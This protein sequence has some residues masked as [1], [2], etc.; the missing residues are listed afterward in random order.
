MERLTEFLVPMVGRLAQLGAGESGWLGQ[1][2]AAAIVIALVAVAHLLLRPLAVRILSAI[3]RRTEADWDDVLLERKVFHRF[4]QLI[5]ALILNTVLPLLFP[6]ES[7][8]QLAAERLSLAYLAVV[9]AL[10]VH[11]VLTASVEIYNRAHVDAR[12]RRP[13]LAYVQVI[14]ILVWIYSIVLIVAI[15]LGRSPLAMLGG[16]GAMTAVLLLVFKDSILGLVA[17]IQVEAN[18]MV[19]VGDWIEIPSFGL[20]GEV[21]RISLTTVKVRNF[22]K[23]IT[24]F[25]THKLIT[26][27]FRNWRGMS[28]SGM[29][30]IKRSIPIDVH[31]VRFADEALRA[32]VAEL[33]HLDEALAVEQV[34]NV[35]LYRAY[36]EGYLRSHPE[37]VVDGATCLVRRLQPSEVGMPL[38]VYAF[39]RRTAFAEY[40]VIQGDILDHLVAIAPRFGVEIFQRPGGRDT[41]ASQ[42]SAPEQ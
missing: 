41:A 9:A 40:E 14:Q 8:V 39:C 12:H 7:G 5:P 1:L 34:T 38:E 25:P 17:S 13:I 32:S 30:R 6:D 28:D 2:T 16:L 21:A 18:D 42:G 23:S 15:L 35:G 27:A 26:E 33:P 4:A 24:N 3:A 20:D 11:S 31:S 22:D 19:R 29:R 37:I 36:A 10:V